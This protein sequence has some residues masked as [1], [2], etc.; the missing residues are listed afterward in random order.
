M[1]DEI[2]GFIYANIKPFFST[3]SK[4]FNKQTQQFLVTSQQLL[5]NNLSFRIQYLLQATAYMAVPI[6]HPGTQVLPL[7]LRIYWISSWVPYST[8]L[9]VTS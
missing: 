9:R 7:E 8:I 3:N 5:L 1:Y 6:L 2:L 4:I